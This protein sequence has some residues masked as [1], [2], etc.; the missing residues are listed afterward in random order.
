M[1][2]QAFFL[3]CDIFKALRSPGAPKSCRQQTGVV[4]G[5][6][7]KK[8][9]SWSQENFG[10]ILNLIQNM[11]VWMLEITRESSKVKAIIATLVQQNTSGRVESYS[12]GHDVSSICET[13]MFY[14]RFQ[15]A[16]LLV[17]TLSQMKPGCTMFLTVTSSAHSPFPCV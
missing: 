11:N 3:L 16:V 12:A 17:P 9:E 7:H 4:L 1:Q 15:N 2:Y 13:W 6:G 14:Y 5:W 10:H 8:F